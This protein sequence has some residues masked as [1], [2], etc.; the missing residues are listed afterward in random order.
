MKPAAPRDSGRPASGIQAWWGAGGW[1]AAEWGA[2]RCSAALTGHC[3]VSSI[4]TTEI[5]LELENTAALSSSSS[6]DSGWDITPV[7]FWLLRDGNRWPHPDGAQ[8]GLSSC[9]LP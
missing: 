4:L 1:A 7:C 5:E 9:L 6:Y 8:A 3:Y 2:G